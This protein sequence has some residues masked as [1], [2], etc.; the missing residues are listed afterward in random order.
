MTLKPCTHLVA[1]VALHQRG[2]RSKAIISTYFG[3]ES[4]WFRAKTLSLFID[5]AS[6]VG[7]KT[8]C[9]TATLDPFVV[10]LH[11]HIFDSYVRHV[12]DSTKHEYVHN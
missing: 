1:V 8:V 7:E 9:R 12:V 3:R 11:F 4:A 10:I 6:C 5:F 2:E